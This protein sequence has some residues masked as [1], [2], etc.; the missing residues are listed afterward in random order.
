MSQR[1]LTYAAA[2]SFLTRY[3][4]IMAELYKTHGRSLQRYLIFSQVLSVCSS[5]SHRDGPPKR[6][7]RAQKMVWLTALRALLD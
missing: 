2:A 7:L 1:D 3:H 6:S 5:K 4:L